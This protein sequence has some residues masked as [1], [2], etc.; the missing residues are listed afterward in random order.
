MEY[1]LAEVDVA[2]S[3]YPKFREIGMWVLN[4]QN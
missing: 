3:L 4:D 2:L 1:G